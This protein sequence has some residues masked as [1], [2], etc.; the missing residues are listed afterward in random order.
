MKQSCKQYFKQI[1]WT[2]KQDLNVC[3]YVF[4][5]EGSRW[6]H[7][8]T[9]QPSETCRFWRRRIAPRH[10]GTVTPAPSVWKPYWS[11]GSSLWA[12][13]YTE[14]WW[15]HTKPDNKIT[16]YMSVFSINIIV[17]LNDIITTVTRFL[18]QIT[19]LVLVPECPIVLMLGC[20][21]PCSFYLLNNRDRSLFEVELNTASWIDAMGDT[22]GV[23]GVWS[24]WK[25][26][27]ISSTDDSRD[28]ISARK[29]ERT[30]I[31]IP[32]FFIFRRYLFVCVRQMLLVER[33]RLLKE[34]GCAH[35]YAFTRMLNCWR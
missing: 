35:D 17:I 3:E 4:V 34:A 1:H 13:P 6:T 31:H 32:D 5:G 12:S 24:T 26:T 23:T 8:P 28:V 9:D 14:Y 11:S 29:Y 33:V 21:N 27:P 10:W 18:V 30:H 16:F 7:P 19:P 22:L 15:A 2:V 20:F 25:H